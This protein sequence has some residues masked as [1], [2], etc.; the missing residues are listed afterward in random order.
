MNVDV[1][2]SRLQKVITERGSGAYVLTVTD[3]GRPHAV[4]LHVG[5]E[6]GR[7]IASGVGATT[8]ANATARPSVSVLF[9]VSAAAEYT[10]FVDGAATVE[11]RGDERRL[12]V[13]PTRGVLHR[14]G[15]PR[16]PA[17]SCTSDCVPLLQAATP[18][19][20]PR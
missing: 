9:P 2:L 12:V 17:S 15:T 11:T 19:A 5:W 7:L 1:E 13:T 8:A 3:D 18:V 6:G 14:P 10:L 20:P 16:D 4:Y